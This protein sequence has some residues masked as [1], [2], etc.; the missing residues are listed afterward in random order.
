MGR[1]NRLKIMGI[2]LVLL[3]TIIVAISTINPTLSSPTN[4]NH[5]KEDEVKE[6]IERLGIN[7]KGSWPEGYTGF[8]F[9]VIGYRDGYIIAR[10]IAVHGISDYSVGEIIYM[11]P[12]KI[13][14]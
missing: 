10:I 9:E 5:Q 1:M 11:K 3:T 8:E 14:N 7:G 12:P 2:M 6:V 4:Q 13:P